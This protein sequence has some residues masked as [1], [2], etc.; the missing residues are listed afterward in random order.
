MFIKF[1]EKFR[2]VF[3]LMLA[4]SL[5]ALPAS[6]L[7]LAQ[8]KAQGLVQE[9]VSGYLKVVKSRKDAEDLVKSINAGRKAEYQKIAK[10]RGTSL[11]AV[12]QLAGKRLTQ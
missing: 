11:S 1:K 10:K 4:L 5:F 2:W 6:A 12:E 3:P 9:T 8:A 7:D